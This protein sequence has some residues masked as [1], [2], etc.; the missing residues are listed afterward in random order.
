VLAKRKWRKREG[1]A[2]GKKGKMNGVPKFQ[3]SGLEL[4]EG[5]VGKL[6]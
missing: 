6:N 1:A 5:E 3:C 4:K 2:L